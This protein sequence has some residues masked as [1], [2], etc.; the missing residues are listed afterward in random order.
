[1]HLFPCT[2]KYCCYI[3][4]AW[5]I[6]LSIKYVAPPRARAPS[7]YCHSLAKLFPHWRRVERGTYM[8]ERGCTSPR[9]NEPITKLST[10]YL[11][12]GEPTET[13][14]LMRGKGGGGP[15]RL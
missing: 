4:S 11:T 9:N 8:N 6:A 3:A 2:C 15:R 14:A 13:G 5:Y 10:I 1:M 7:Y 12:Y